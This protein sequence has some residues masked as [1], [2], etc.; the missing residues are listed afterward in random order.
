MNEGKKV[1]EQQR[2]TVFIKNPNDFV[3]SVITGSMPCLARS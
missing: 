3:I 1:R 2:C